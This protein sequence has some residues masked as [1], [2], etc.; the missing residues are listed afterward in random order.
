MPK[1]KSKQLNPHFTGS[2]DVSGSLAVD[3][4][5]IAR[6][7]GEDTKALIVSGAMDIAQSAVASAS[8]AIDNLG[9]IGDRDLASIIDLG[10]FQ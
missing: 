2:F 3:G 9:T 6:Q 1:I 10:E 8:L 4:Q 7:I 5:L